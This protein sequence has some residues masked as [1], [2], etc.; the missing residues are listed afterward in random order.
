MVYH[1]AYHPGFE[2]DL[3]YVVAIVE[4]EEGPHIL[5]NIVCCSPD[6]VQCDMQVELTWDDITEEFSLPK[7]TPVS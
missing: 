3:P 5:T 7:F 2:K 6:E 1:V 4:L